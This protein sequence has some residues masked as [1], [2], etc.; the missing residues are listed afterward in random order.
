MFNTYYAAPSAT[1]DKISAP[2]Q[3]STLLPTI[4]STFPMISTYKIS[5]EKRRLLSTY[6]WERIVT[7]GGE[8][9]ELNLEDLLMGLTTKYGQPTKYILSKRRR[10]PKVEQSY[11]PILCVITAHK[12]K[13]HTESD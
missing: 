5:R 4:Y 8:L 10:Y 1:S 13:K 6:Y 7:H 11:M 12:N 9:L 3:H 2:K